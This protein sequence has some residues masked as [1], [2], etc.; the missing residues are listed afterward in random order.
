MFNNKVL[1]SINNDGLDTV[2][3]DD[4]QSDD[5][6]F[7]LSVGGKGIGSQTES[8]QLFNL[9]RRLDQLKANYKK[10]VSVENGVRKESYL[11]RGIAK[12]KLCS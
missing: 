5:G 3:D 12:K 11:V 7:V 4:L 9:K 2:T 6:Y 8:N 10:I 1:N